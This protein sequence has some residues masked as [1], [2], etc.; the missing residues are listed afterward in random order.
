MCAYHGGAVG[1]SKKNTNAANDMASTATVK[2]RNFVRSTSHSTI[3]TA[4]GNR[5]WQK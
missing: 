4:M 5:K 2:R 3:P 1:S